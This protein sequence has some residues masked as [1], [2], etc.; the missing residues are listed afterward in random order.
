[1]EGSRKLLIVEDDRSL[2]RQ[3]RWAFDAYEVSQAE[4]RKGAL[5]VAVTE[6]P[7][8]VLLD[9]GLPPDPDGPTEGLATL[10][11]LLSLIPETKV[12]VMTG[13]ADRAYAVKAVAKGAY[14]YYQK[15][16]ELDDLSLIVGRALELWNLEEEFRRIS[17]AGAVGIPGF[18]TMN[19]ELQK[20]LR[21]VRDLADSDVSALILGESGTGKE[22][23][24]KGIH[25]LSRRNGGN[26][27]VINCAAIPDQLLES[28]LF[29]HEKGAFTD[30]FKTTVGRVEIANDGT[31]FL[32]EIGDL[33]MGLQAK[34]L[35][36]LQERVIERVG[37]REQIPIDVRIISA[38]N[39][40]LVDAIGRGEFRE[41]LYYR[42]SEYTINIPPLRERPDDTIMIAN[43]YLREFAREQGRAVRGFTDEAL[44]AVSNYGWPGNVREIQNRI[45][46]A[47]I[48]A[49][50][51]RISPEN[52]GLETTNEKPVVES[53]RDTRDRAERQAIE[54]AMAAANGNIS[55]AAK[56]LQISRPKLYDLMRAHKLKA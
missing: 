2:R 17:T 34:L 3:L 41:D 33:S 45:K 25:Q 7:S 13:Q 4:D 16:I 47:V 36:F 21:Q 55:K 27:V 6:R 8:V 51:N 22:L 53:L 42:L 35:R 49:Q 32:D 28:E 31:L 19:A 24:A 56:I 29:G 14:D 11:E 40:N 43:H 1:M 20:I 37:G 54:R 5:D 52:L 10:D 44:A 12:I 30:A 50:A 15:P 46:R 48:T 9:L 18:L 26:F 23:L 39:K 38:T